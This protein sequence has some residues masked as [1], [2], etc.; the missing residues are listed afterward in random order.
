MISGILCFD[1]F[2]RIPSTPLFVLA[3][4]D[5][6]ILRTS[7]LIYE[8]KIV[9]GVKLWYGPMLVKKSLN[10]LATSNHHD[11]F[12]IL[13]S[14]TII[15]SR[16]TSSFN[17]GL[18]LPN[19]LLKVFM[20]VCL[21]VFVFSCYFYDDLMRTKVILLYALRSEIRVLRYLVYIS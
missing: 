2:E 6:V 8:V 15:I 14:S 5:D 18:F 21:F 17:G 7:S 9:G 16:V 11:H 3:F 4:N 10:L 1:K 13:N 20:F 12:R 19:N